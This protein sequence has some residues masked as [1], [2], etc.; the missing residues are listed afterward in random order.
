MAARYRTHPA[1]FACHVYV[2]RAVA[3]G[4]LTKG[5]TCESCGRGDRPVEGHHYRSYRR[6]EWYTVQWVC[7]SCHRLAHTRMAQ[8]FGNSR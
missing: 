3:Q 8:G 7:R 2:G 4:R 5:T 6:T 1:A